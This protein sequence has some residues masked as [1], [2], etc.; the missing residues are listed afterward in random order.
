MCSCYNGYCVN[1]TCVCYEGWTGI[2]DF[3]W[4]QGSSC[5][6]NKKCVY[7]A[8]WI[9]IALNIIVILLYSVFLVSRLNEKFTLTTKTNWFIIMFI[10]EAI[11]IGLYNASAV[12][13]EV[14]LVPG[15]TVWVTVVLSLGWLYALFGF[16]L[17]LS[18][19][20]DYMKRVSRMMSA[21]Y[22]S[23]V[24][25][26]LAVIEGKFKYMYWISFFNSFIISFGIV[27]HERAYYIVAMIFWIGMG[28]WFFIYICTL[29][30]SIW[31]LRSAL[32]DGV[33]GSD[34]PA[35]SDTKRVLLYVQCFL[36]VLFGIL[37]AS[38]FYVGSSKSGVGKSIYVHLL[39][40]IIVHAMALPM[41]YT[42]T[43]RPDAVASNQVSPARIIPARVVTSAYV[44]NNQIP[45]V[46]NR[47]E[48]FLSSN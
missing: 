31:I 15:K 30:V 33:G 25:T 6:I 45:A 32:Q 11:S 12:V 23:S 13:D 18:I 24:E 2:G 14:G 47:N 7:I 20:F 29:N 3:N 27:A 8:S 10:C 16:L 46:F 28:C 26:S 5:V 35:A 34:I 41:L 39:C 38:F 48:V 19:S 4:N 22:R 42:L 36:S 17:Y 9:S 43:K 1:N 21:E 44:R 37:I 40:S